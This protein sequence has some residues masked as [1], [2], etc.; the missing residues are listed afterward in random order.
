MGRAATFRWRIWLSIIKQRGGG[1]G[2]TG[3][4]EMEKEREGVMACEEGPMT[5]RVLIYQITI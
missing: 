5:W 1:P 3:K 2:Q 4:S